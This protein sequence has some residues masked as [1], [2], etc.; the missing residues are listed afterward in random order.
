MFR[1]VAQ[2]LLPLANGLQRIDNLRR[3]PAFVLAQYM[4]QWW[5]GRMRATQVAQ[6]PQQLALVPLGDPYGV[7]FTGPIFEWDHLIY[8]YL[9]ENTRIYDIFGRVIREYTTGERLGIPRQAETY[10]WL[11]TTEDVFYSYGTSFL[12]GSIVS[13]IRPDIRAT[14]RNA[15]YRL[16]GLDLNSSES[17]GPYPYEKPAAA[18]RAFIAIFES[19]LREVWRAIENATN[20]VG[21]NPT[22][23]A[24]IAD[25]ALRLQNMLVERRGVAAGDPNLAREEFAAVCAMSWLE[26][27]VAYDNPILLDLQAT[28][29]SPEER[30]RKIGVRVGLPSDA[31]AHSYFILAPLLSWLLG[32]I[33]SGTFSNAL[34]VQDLY[35]PI[36]GNQDRLDM[37]QIIAHWSRATGRDMKV[38]SVGSTSGATPR[39]FTPGRVAVPPT[40]ANG[41]G[42]AV[43]TAGQLVKV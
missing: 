42:A 21:A 29:D 30:L 36:A 27:V 32:M 7:V 14:R 33:E 15:Y 6:P 34:A 23:D 17:G 5:A 39:V 20:Q 40:T 18:N 43:T 10:D 9:I 16:F 31:N 11:R 2:T 25:V 1:Q 41:N 3:E 38:P 28:A 26:L 24:A 37:M 13:Q 19:F 4:E 8:A 22:D 35:W 12:S